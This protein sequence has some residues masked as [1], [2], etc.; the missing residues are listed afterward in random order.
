MCI[1]VYMLRT[2]MAIAAKGAEQHIEQSQWNE[3]SIKTSLPYMG[4]D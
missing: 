4:H 2:Y 3:I 1:W